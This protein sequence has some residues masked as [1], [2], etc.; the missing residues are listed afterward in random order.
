MNSDETKQIHD[1]FSQL[2]KNKDGVVEFSELRDYINELNKKQISLK[3]DQTNE[4]NNGQ[5]AEHLFEL[6]KN[7]TSNSATINFDFR[8]FLEYVNQSDRKI[9]LLFKDLD[10]DRNGIIDKN[11]SI[12]L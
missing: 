2:D 3:N 10:R 7:S 8:D 11:G 6:I 5:Q 12:S 4:K 9:Q 1:L